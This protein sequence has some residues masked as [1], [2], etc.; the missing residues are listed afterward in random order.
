LQFLLIMPFVRPPS[1]KGSTNLPYWLSPIVAL[2]ILSLGVVYYTIRFVA[3]P[4]AFGYTLEAVAVE[5]SDG[6]AVTRY[7]AKKIQ[8]TYAK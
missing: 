7:K 8:S 5:L 4:W 2:A 3:L 1:G 6:S